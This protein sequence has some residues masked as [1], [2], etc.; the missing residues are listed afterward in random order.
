[1]RL[2]VR[3]EPARNLPAL[4]SRQQPNLALPIRPPYLFDPEMVEERIRP[5]PRTAE[6]IHAKK[7]VGEQ[8]GAFP[9]LQ[10]TDREI[11]RV[12]GRANGYKHLEELLVSLERCLA[13]GWD[14]HQLGARD[15][16]EFASLMSDLQVA[17]H[18][19]LREF[20]I[21]SPVGLRIEG[22]K[23]DLYVRKGA[24]GA[25]IEVFRPRELP[26][27]HDFLTDVSRLLIE[28]DVRLDYHADVKLECAS[29][30]D[31]AGRLVS[32][33]HPIDLDDALRPMAEEALGRVAAALAVLE[34][35]QE[36]TLVEQWPERNL[37]LVVEFE[38]VRTSGGSEPARSVHCGKSYGG[39]EPVGMLA[40]LM[41]PIVAKAKNRQAG[42]R[43]DEARVLICDISQAI[44]AAHLDEPY[45]KE[46]FVDVLKREL[47]PQ[48][49]RNYDVIALCESR[50]WHMPLRL[51]FA[52]SADGYSSVV[53]E[54]FG[55]VATVG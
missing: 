3:A 38:D 1:M 28:T 49:E 29:D 25:I 45:R 47:E 44:V 21:E 35:A 55:S 18:C 34:P 16:D 2:L 20:A 4:A 32:P 13:S 8:S 51:D 43:G 24:L 54:L 10:K 23:P 15:R 37:K 36:R 9:R 27:F 30:F 46:R 26:A 22:T 11:L 14:A 41:K 39:Y 6:L 17:E 31:A 19:L 52:V 50:G 40:R 48:V 7:R 12:L 33:W 53:G 42:E 5:R